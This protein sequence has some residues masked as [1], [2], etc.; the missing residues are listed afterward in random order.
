[1][2]SGHHIVDGGK[3]YARF[4]PRCG[5]PEDDYTVPEVARIVVARIVTSTLGRG[6]GYRCRPTYRRNRFRF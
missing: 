4:S 5:R 1:M 6:R 3:G 2:D